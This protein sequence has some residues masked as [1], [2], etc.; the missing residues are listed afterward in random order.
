VSYQDFQGSIPDD[1]A[2]G[3][4]GE[5]TYAAGPSYGAYQGTVPPDYRVWATAAIIGGILFSLIIGLP[6]G[7]VARAQSRRVR[8]MWQKGDAQGALKASRSA[9]TWVIAATIFNVLGLIFAIWLISR[10]G[11]PTS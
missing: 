8:S 1:P 9:L 2:Q 11:Q 6:L 7:L 3:E 4:Y 10:G 5:P